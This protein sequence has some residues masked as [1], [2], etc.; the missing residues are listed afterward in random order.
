[1]SL[2]TP[3]ARARGHGS[4]HSGVHHWWVQRLTALALLPLTVW[5][6]WGAVSV[7]GGD[8]A[9]I[10]AWVAQPWNVAAWLAFIFALFYHIALGLQ[11]VVEDYVHTR[12]VELPLQIGIKFACIALGLVAIL[13]V[14]RVAF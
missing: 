8:H 12:S 14:L 2:V 13:A 6:L 7:A 10:V 1:M 5:L 4:A 9:A 11:V 3:V